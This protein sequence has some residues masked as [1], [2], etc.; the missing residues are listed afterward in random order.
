[1]TVKSAP[2]RRT[3]KN[4]Q[5]ASLGHAPVLRH[6]KSRSKLDAVM[7]AVSSIELTETPAWSD[8]DSLSTHTSIEDIEAVPEGIF[9]TDDN[10]FTAVATVYVGL[11]YGDK[12]DAVTASDSF[13][14][15]I[16][17][18]FEQGGKAVVDSVSVDTGSF[19]E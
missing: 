9:E 12:D 6:L 1:M 13:P 14:A 7:D 2:S 10:G 11:N 3:G 4:A 17:G 15:Q 5:T 8:L 18:R 16:D 19:Y